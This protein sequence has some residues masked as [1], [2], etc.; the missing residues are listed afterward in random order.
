MAYAFSMKQPA[1]SFAAIEGEG[2]SQK[3][4]VGESRRDLRE[5]GEEELGSQKQGRPAEALRDRW[6]R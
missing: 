3:P 4:E 6:R 2:E 1:R 5:N